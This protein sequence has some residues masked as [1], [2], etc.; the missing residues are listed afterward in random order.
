[1]QGDNLAFSVRESKQ[2]AI[3]RL[4]WFF[5]GILDRRRVSISY[6][7]QSRE[8]VGLAGQHHLSLVL[9]LS[10]LSLQSQE[11]VAC[12]LSAQTRLTNLGSPLIPNFQGPLT[13]FE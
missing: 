3:A 7:C 13:P 4:P 12:F 8:Q 10:V 2:V 9:C 5:A 6:V 11:F 1:V